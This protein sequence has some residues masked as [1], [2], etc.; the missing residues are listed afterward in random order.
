MGAVKSLVVSVHDAAPPY[1]EALKNISSWL[2]DHS[3]SPRCIK[4]IPNYL[5]RWNI[6]EHKDFLTWLK[7]ERDKGSEILQHGYFHAESKKAKSPGLWL[8]DRFITRRN[9]EFINADYEQAMAAIQNGQNILKKASFPC[10][11]FTSPTWYQSRETANALSDCGFLYYTSYTRIIDGRRGK[12]VLSSAMGDLGLGFP[13]GQMNTIK[14]FFMAST[15]FHCSPLARVVLHPQTPPETLPFTF[16]LNSILMLARKREIV[17][18]KH[19][20]ES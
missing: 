11:G 13:L 7:E 19:F 15:G 3:V 14:N 10:Q 6:L 5:G 4:V 1:L 9:A 12:H 2:D 20:V 18:Y 17:T 16:A 8:R